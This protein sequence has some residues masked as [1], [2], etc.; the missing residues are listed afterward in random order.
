MPTREINLLPQE[1]QLEKEKEKRRRNVVFQFTILAVFFTSLFVLGAFLF[2][3]YL[4][5]QATTVQKK[6]GIERQ[7]IER[8]KDREILLLWT[9]T[10][11]LG[12]QKILT[13]RPLYESQ[14]AALDLVMSLMKEGLFLSEY[15][16]DGP[17]IKFL[18]LAQNSDELATLVNN[19]KAR[20]EKETLFGTIIINSV[21]L[22]KTG[23]YKL[24][25][26]LILAGQDSREKAQEKEV[27]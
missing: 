10:K 9:K 5:N 17:E 19:L 25:F 16:F 12:I 1:T 23:G 21:D 27:F 4:K 26:S 7:K 22:Q 13:A 15:S 20:N 2:S 24:S 11:I 14:L 3:L 8:A 6:I 18:V